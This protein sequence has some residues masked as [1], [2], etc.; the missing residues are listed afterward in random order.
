MIISNLLV[1]DCEST[2]LDRS[3][4]QIIEL[5]IQFGLDDNAMGTT[6]RFRPDVPIAPAATAVHGICFE[7]V[8]HCPSFADRA[9]EVLRVLSGATVLVGYNLD[10]DVGMLTAELGRCGRQLDL[11]A[12]L[13]VDPLQLWRKKEPRDLQSAH[14]RF[15]GGEF[16]GAHGAAADVAATGRVL[17]GMLRDWAIPQ[18]W[19]V[20]ADLCNPDRA[21]WVGP[22]HHLQ[23]K[24]GRIV[25]S[26]GKH[27]G[28]PLTELDPGYV[29]WMAKDRRFPPHVVQLCQRAVD[30]P[31]FDEWAKTQ[32][33]RAA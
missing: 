26:F 20:V 16:H 29:R 32:Y 9:D 18:D 3:R 12:K 21:A 17:L 33:R 10:F 5:C 8:A 7:M 25:L 1:L 13:L 2:G 27:S 22:S 24:D 14:Q 6:W 11:S 4:D 15:V 30:D 19:A 28:T 31:G 23:W